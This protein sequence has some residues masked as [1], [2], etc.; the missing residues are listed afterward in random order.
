[1]IDLCTLVHSAI[2]HAMF[3]KHARLWN[4]TIQKPACTKILKIDNK[5]DAPIAALSDWPSESHLKM[6]HHSENRSEHRPSAMS[7]R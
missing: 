1:L 4:H 5:K 2:T 6:W 3:S 7:I